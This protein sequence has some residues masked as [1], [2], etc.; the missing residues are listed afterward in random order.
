[1]LALIHPSQTSFVAGLNITDNIMIAQK[2]IHNMRT[3]KSK[4]GWMAIKF[5]LEK[6]YDRLSWK[7]IE[8]TL[9]D[10]RIPQ[11][12]TQV[13][14]SCLYSTSM[15][16]I[17]DGKVGAPFNPNRG[18]HQG[19]PLSLYIFV[20]CMERLSQAILKAVQDKIWKPICF[21]KTETSHLFFVNDLILFGEASIQEMKVVRTPFL[22]SVLILDMQLVEVNPCPTAQKMWAKR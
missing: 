17:W 4:K 16:V 13:I 22:I 18:I 20:L 8:D 21:G 12:L 10:A 15:Q 7:F 1:M 2:V 6:A 3:K 14:L 11:F 19:D 5:D 9:V